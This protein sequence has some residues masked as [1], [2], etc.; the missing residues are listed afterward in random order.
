M[1]TIL[2]A[3]LL[4]LLSIL[5]AV[6]LTISDGDGYDVGSVSDYSGTY[7]T[8]IGHSPRWTMV[9]KQ[10][11][12]D[13]TY[14]MEGE[15]KT[16]AGTGTVSG[17]TMTLT[18]EIAS[19]VTI[20][21]TFSSDA[22]NFFGTF[23]ITGNNPIQGSITGTKSAWAIYDVDLNGIPRFIAE[24][25]IELEKIQKVSKFRS[26]EGHDYSDDFESCRSMKHYFYPEDGVDRATVK[27]FSPVNG[28]VIGTTEEWDGPELWKGTVVGIKA[29]DY[30]AFHLAIFH[31]NLNNPLNVGD[32]VTA[33]QEL[34][35]SQKVSGTVSDFAVGVH[36]PNGYK[37]LSYFDVMTNSLFQD[38]QA[39]GVVS[40]DEAIIS[41]E[42]RDA[43][44]LTCDG[45]EFVGSGNLENR[46]I[47]N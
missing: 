45:E 8:T 13:V 29:K 15:G 30:E 32:I 12:N 4:T 46:I 25:G 14:T 5:L 24:G 11:G 39:R 40:R 34:G 21:A 35:K 7:Y 6:S 36:T 9:I 18:A 43:D 41:K 42:E 22:Q 38:Y 23:D 1:K 16:V 26:G 2:R 37:L 33:G 27:I 31:I 20:L 17:N 44:P 3:S 47:L 19:T 28:V 10:S